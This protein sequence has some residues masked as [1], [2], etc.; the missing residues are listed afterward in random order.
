MREAELLG[1][2]RRLRLETRGDGS[3]VLALEAETPTRVLEESGLH[4][5][6]EVHVRIARDAVHLL[7][8]HA[9]S[10]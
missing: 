10:G 3:D 1:A 6:A 4:P 8:R 7:E 9:G 2:T 5:G